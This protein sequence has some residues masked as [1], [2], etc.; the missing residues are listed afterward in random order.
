ME[1]EPKFVQVA[2]E[3]WEAFSGERAERAEDA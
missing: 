1:L 2:I 3:R